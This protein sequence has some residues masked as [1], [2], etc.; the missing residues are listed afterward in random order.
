MGTR[1]KQKNQRVGWNPKFHLGHEK[2]C[3]RTIMKDL[4][5]EWTLFEFFGKEEKGGREK[6]EREG[7]AVNYNISRLFREMASRVNQE[8][9]T[10]KRITELNEEPEHPMNKK[11]NQKGKKPLR[12][13]VA[14][15]RDD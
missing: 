2:F 8:H 13:G 9:N 5:L 7:R 3:I 14:P 4:I 1:N 12:R 6:N 15:L 10:S 11:T